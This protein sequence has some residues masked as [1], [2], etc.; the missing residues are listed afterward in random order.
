MALPNM[1]SANHLSRL[2][3]QP[4]AS[5][6]SDVRGIR[7]AEGSERWLDYNLNDQ[8]EVVTDAIPVKLFLD[9]P[10]PLKDLAH[11]APLSYR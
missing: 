5:L 4:D 1:I 9:R 7:F 3:G 2:I 6:L 8:I 11:E 10:Q